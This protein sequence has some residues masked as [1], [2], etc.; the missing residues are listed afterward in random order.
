L[1]IATALRMRMRKAVQMR[2][3]RGG[4]RHVAWSDEVLGA[5]TLIQLYIGSE[6]EEL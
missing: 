3:Q 4:S 2:S 6:D 1:E 5:E